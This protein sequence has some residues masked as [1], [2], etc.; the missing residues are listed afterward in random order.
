[1][2]SSSSTL[3]L[4]KGVTRVDLWMKAFADFKEHP[5]GYGLGKAGHV[6][7]RFFG[8]N[9]SEAS[10][11][12]TDG[13]FLKIAGETGLWGLSTYFFLAVSFIVRSLNY[14]R[15]KSYSLFHFLLILFVVVNIQCLVSNVIDFY[16]LSYLFWL[17]LGLAENIKSIRV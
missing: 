13:W 3:I 5:L 2:K 6:A 9:S 11:S 1:M 7:T 15:N 10:V 8:K 16:L 12:S 4:E 14:I 17:S